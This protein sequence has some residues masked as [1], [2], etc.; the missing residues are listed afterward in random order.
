MQ[1]ENAYW[2]ETAAEP[3]STEHLSHF[4]GPGFGLD[5]QIGLRYEDCTMKFSLGKRIRDMFIPTLAYKS[6]RLLIPV[7]LIPRLRGC[8]RSTI[9]R[10]VN[11]NGGCFDS[12]AV[13]ESQG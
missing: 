2:S 3:Q 9:S 6:A 8:R 4:G 7:C 1:R 5:C 13:S 10:S 11:S 12:V